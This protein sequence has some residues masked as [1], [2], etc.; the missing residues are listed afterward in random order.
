MQGQRNWLPL[1]ASA[2]IGT[3]AYYSMTRGQG[4][5]QIVQRFAPL[6]AG[7]SGQGQQNSQQ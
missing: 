4:M 7:M 1:L 2:G 3:S 5:G 6:V